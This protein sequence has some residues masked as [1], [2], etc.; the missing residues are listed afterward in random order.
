MP[1]AKEGQLSVK[2]TMRKL[3]VPQ[4]AGRQLPKADGSRITGSGADEMVMVRLKW[5]AHF[6]L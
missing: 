4:S 6:K 2:N 5:S 1:T 3:S